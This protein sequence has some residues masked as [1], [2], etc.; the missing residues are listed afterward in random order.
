M[1]YT[2]FIIEKYDIIILDVDSKDTGVGMT[3]P[4]IQ[5][6]E[7]QFLEACHYVIKDSG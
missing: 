1:F 3:C 5:F 4:P 7:Q 2:P 6:L